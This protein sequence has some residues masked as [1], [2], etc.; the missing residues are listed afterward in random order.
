[1]TS[2]IQ[3]ALEPVERLL[4]IGEVTRIIGADRRVILAAMNSGALPYR[5]IDRRSFVALSD[6]LTFKNSFL[7]FIRR[8]G[9][10]RPAS[11]NEGRRY[12]S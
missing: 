6:A 5:S 3:P 7:Q 9:E 12:V 8:A 10:N 11:R 2:A 4:T 1:M